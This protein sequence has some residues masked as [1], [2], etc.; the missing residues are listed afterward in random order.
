MHLEYAEM[1]MSFIGGMSFFRAADW[2]D[3]V[4]GK[5]DGS[6]RVGLAANRWH[7]DGYLGHRGG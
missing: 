2:A 1:G 7:F 6:H 3:Y 5:T 4:V